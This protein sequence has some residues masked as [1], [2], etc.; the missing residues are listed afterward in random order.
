[1]IALLA[2]PISGTLSTYVLCS[3]DLL[4]RKNF[5]KN[6]RIIVEKQKEKHACGLYHIRIVKYLIRKLLIV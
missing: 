4:M 2:L 3:F 1:M 5:T 6:Q